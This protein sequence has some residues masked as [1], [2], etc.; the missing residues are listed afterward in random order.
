M[1]WMRLV[2]VGSVSMILLL[3]LLYANLFAL[4]RFSFPY[5]MSI[6]MSITNAPEVPFY[7]AY[8]ACAG[9]L[10][11][12]ISMRGIDLYGPAVGAMIG[13]TSSALLSSIA[14]LRYY[15]HED[16][17]SRNESVERVHVRVASVFI[18]GTLLMSTFLVFLNPSRTGRGMLLLGIQAASVCVLAVS[19]ARAGEIMNAEGSSAARYSDWMRLFASQEVICSACF[20]SILWMFAT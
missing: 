5:D 7:T 17:L 9:I 18:F 19:S 3:S 14:F 6:S 15:E 2:R 1:L 20:L 11:M 8:A 12:G 13:V 10:V 16:P 4:D